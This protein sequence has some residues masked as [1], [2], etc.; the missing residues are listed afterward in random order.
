MTCNMVRVDNVIRE[1]GRMEDML[2]LDE[3]IAVAIK[4]KM[5]LVAMRKEEEMAA[6]RL[7]EGE[8]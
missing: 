3:V 2:D 1:V 5:E 6:E 7:A 8:Q 4:R